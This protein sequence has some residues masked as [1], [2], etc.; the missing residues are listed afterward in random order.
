MGNCTQYFLTNYKTKESEME[1]IYKIHTYIT[2][3]VIHT[4]IICEVIHIY[5]THIYM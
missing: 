3:E 4:Y 1:Y 5:N 2:C